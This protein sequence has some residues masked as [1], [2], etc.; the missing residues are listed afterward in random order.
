MKLIISF[1][2]LLV[3]LLS[4][5]GANKSQQLKVLK[6]EVMEVH[7]EVMPKMG[8]MR[9][10][11]KS[12]M[13]KAETM[14]SSASAELKE[15]AGEIEAA[16]EFMME[17]MRQYE[18][19]LEGTEEELLKYYNEQRAGIQEVKERMLSALEKGQKALSE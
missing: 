15:I 1:S 10:T 8:D 4:S 12:L 18:P 17:W 9:K 19:N 14:D 3:M 16:N 6:D 11:S 13:M 5:C 7:D 2:I